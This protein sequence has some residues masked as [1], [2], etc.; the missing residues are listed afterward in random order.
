MHINSSKP[1]HQ[2]SIQLVCTSLAS[3]ESVQWVVHNV[4]R[5]KS[6]TSPVKL[7]YSPW[8]EKLDYMLANYTSSLYCSTHCYCSIAHVVTLS[9]SHSTLSV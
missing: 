4:L 6:L 2:I 1:C 5:S 8:Q 3:D 7:A 9:C